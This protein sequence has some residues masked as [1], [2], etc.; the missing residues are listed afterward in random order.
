MVNAEVG[1]VAGHNCPGSACV[2]R[3]NS[4]LGNEADVQ[5]RSVA[6]K[7]C[8]GSACVIRYNSDFEQNTD[9]SKDE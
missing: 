2:I 9:A 3:Y 4:D 1:S 6:E 5:V 8:P 7:N